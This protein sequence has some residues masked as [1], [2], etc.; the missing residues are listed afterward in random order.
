MRPKRLPRTWGDVRRDWP[1]LTA[2]QRFETAVG[3][4]LTLVIGAVVL[5]AL[6]RLVVGVFDT[7]VLQALNP[8]DH[9]VFQKVFGDILTVLI[10]LEFN[11]TLQVVLARERGVI[12]TKVVILIALLALVRKLIVV[13]FY[14]VSPA[15]LA[16]LSGLLLSLGVTYWLM[17]ERDD[18]AQAP[19]R[20][21]MGSSAGQRNRAGIPVVPTPRDT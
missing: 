3:L 11:H 14:A 5:V 9:G 16:A 15:F 17:R 7:L 8:L 10:A 12:Q 4:V 20:V 13:D 19:R 18:Q 1:M 21:K 6:Y 2:Y